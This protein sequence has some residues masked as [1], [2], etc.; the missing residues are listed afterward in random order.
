ML[1]ADRFVTLPSETQTLSPQVDHIYYDILTPEHVLWGLRSG[2]ASLR[3][4]YSKDEYAAHKKEEDEVAKRTLLQ[5]LQHLF[6]GGQVHFPVSSFD[7]DMDKFL[8]T[9]WALDVSDGEQED[10]GISDGEQE[11]I[12]DVERDY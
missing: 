10:M 9:P 8:R 12:H 5:M 1:F 7:C 11:D 4:L 6:P 2:N 3:R